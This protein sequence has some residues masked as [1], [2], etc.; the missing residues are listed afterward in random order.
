MAP[1]IFLDSLI[2]EVLKETAKHVLRLFNTHAGFYLGS[3][4]EPNNQF[5]DFLQSPDRTIAI[6]CRRNHNPGCPGH[7]RS[8]Y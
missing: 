5:I 6:E 7:S 4:K 2:I 8:S 3:E 1:H